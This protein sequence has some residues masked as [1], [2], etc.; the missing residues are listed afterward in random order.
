[1]SSLI[2][3]A[4]KNSWLYKQADFVVQWFFLLAIASTLYQLDIYLYKYT[5][6]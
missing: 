3:W 1:M 5:S 6:E 2:N 4:Q